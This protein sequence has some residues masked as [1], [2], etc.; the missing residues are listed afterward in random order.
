MGSNLYFEHSIK[1]GRRGLKRAQR[2]LKKAWDWTV[3]DARPVKYALSL[4]VCMK[5]KLS[6]CSRVS[7]V[8]IL[9]LFN[10]ARFV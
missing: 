2:G 9:Q 7:V 5:V 8:D 6:S 3:D 10:R 4:S 1:E